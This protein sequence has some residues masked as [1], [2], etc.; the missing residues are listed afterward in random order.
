MTTHLP[1]EYAGPVSRAIAFALDA[2]V[3]AILFAGGAVVGGLIA[4]V[5]GIGKRDLLRAAVAACLLVLPAV[6]AAY[7]A[8]FWALAGR[9]PG[10]AL[11]GLRVVATGRRSR[12]WLSSLVRAI[13]L[14]YF[15]IGALWLVVDRR[16]QAVHDKLAHT[17]VLRAPAPA[18]VSAATASADR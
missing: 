13:V 7:S 11:L 12:P 17:V 4:S 3:V 18:T 6:L 2:L 8:A 15:P 10:M 1:N 16:H 5:L 14:A 9:T